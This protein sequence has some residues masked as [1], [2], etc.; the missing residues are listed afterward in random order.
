MDTTSR[1]LRIHIAEDLADLFDLARAIPELSAENALRRA[2]VRHVDFPT[3]IRFSDAAACLSVSVPTVRA[4]ISHGVLDEVADA[5]PRAVTA[6]SLGWAIHAARAETPDQVSSRQMYRVLESL[7]DRDMLV[8][9]RRKY[10]ALRD[11]DFVEYTEQDLDEI[12]A[13]V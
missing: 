13:T 9:A 12:L 6:V 3:P 11:D 5:T 1:Q 8:V 7:H 4:W 10:E 2:L